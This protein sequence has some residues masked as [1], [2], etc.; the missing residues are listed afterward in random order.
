[1]AAFSNQRTYISSTWRKHL[2]AIVGPI[3]LNGGLQWRV[4]QRHAE[5]TSPFVNSDA[6]NDEL[7]K[8]NAQDGEYVVVLCNV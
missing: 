3:P 7:K 6:I 4:G 5:D 2:V 1:M 8:A